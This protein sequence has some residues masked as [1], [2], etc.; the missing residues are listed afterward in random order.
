MTGR[1]YII[2]LFVI[3]ACWCFF[4]V[5]DLAMAQEA[6][7]VRVGFYD[8]PPKLFYDA[9][10]IPRGIFP[11]ILA[12]IAKEENW[13]IK[14]VPGTWL[15]GLANLE[16]GSIDIL[17]D[18]AYSLKKAGKYCF[19]EE[20]VFVNWGTLYARSGLLITKIPDLAGKRVAVM[21][22]SIHTDGEEGIRNLVRKF[23]I[24]C[25]FIEFDNY[26][27]VFQ[28]LQ[29]D[30]ADVGVVNRLFGTTSQQL[31]DV[32]PTPVV[33]NPRHLK[34]AFPKNGVATPY[35]KSTIDHHLQSAHLDRDSKITRIVNSYVTDISMRLQAEARQIYLTAEEKAWIKAH[36][37]IRVGID[38]EF[39]PFEYLDDNGNYSGFASDYINLL[40][41]RLGLNLEVVNGLS[42]QEVMHRARKRK[43]DML[44]AIGFS[45]QRSGFLSYSI[46]YS[47]FYRM[48]FCRSDAPFISGVSD[49]KRLKIAVQANTSHSAW[50][51]EHTS[52]VP[53]YYDTLQDTI[54]AVSRGR[55]DV[56]IG[57]LAVCTYWIRKLN[58]TN[59]RVAAPV[60]LERQLLYMGVRKD[61]PQLTGILNKGIRSIS[62]K[63]AEAIRN[64]WLAAGYSVG[65]SRKIIYQRL[66][67]ILF[68]SLFVLAFFWFWNKRLL[69]EIIRRKQAEQSLLAIQGKLVEKVVE[70]T[71]KLEENK[72]YLQSIFNAP[73]EAIF[74]HDAETGAILDVNKTTL[75]MFNVTYEEALQARP[76]DFSQGEY[77]YNAEE[78]LRKIR[79]TGKNG[80][81]T[82]EWLSRKKNGTLFWTEV[83]LTLTSI[84]DRTYIIAVVRNIDEKKK[85][86]QRLRAEQERLAVTLRSIGEG[87]IAVDTKGAVVL[88]NRVAEELTGWSFA[89]AKGVPY[90]KVFTVIDEKSGRQLENPI[91][92]AFQRGTIVG[93]R[94]GVALMAKDGSRKS[95]ADSCAPIRDREGRIIG[96]VLVFRDIT[97]ERKMEEELLK[98][99]K[100]EAVGILA[101]GI[102]HDFNNILTAVTGNIELSIKKAEKNTDVTPL[103]GDAL[104]A[105]ERAEK[106]T[107]QLLTFAKG[108]E[109]IKETASL[110][111]LIRDS[112]DFVLHGSGVSCTYA[113]AEDLWL[114]DVDKGQISQVVQNIIINARQAM[115]AGGT[116]TITCVN[117]AS[118]VDEPFPGLANKKYV[119]IIT[120]DTGTGIA[121][122]DI[123]KVFD[124]FFSSRETGSGLG[125]AICHSIVTKHHGRIF[126]DSTP[127]VGT[128]FT[129]YL[130][131]SDADGERVGDM[132][133]K[134]DGK[135]L[136]SARIMVMDDEELFKKVVK[137][138]LEY[139]G[140][141]VVFV[142][143]GREAVACYRDL[144]GTEEQIDCIIMDLTIPGGVGGKEAVREILAIDPDARV[145]V[146][147]GYFNDPV[148]ANYMEYGFKAAVA[149]PFKLDELQR[150]ISSVFA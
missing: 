125:L 51:R 127:G 30:L 2:L 120:C 19:S 75:T 89:E 97:N 58:I 132:D 95:I 84:S 62:A 65:I 37:L 13:R 23:N 42:W 18:V 148:M 135:N 11:E 32:L 110:A 10:G 146:A 100:L 138:Q 119:K 87:V 60:S 83:S 27:N 129:I 59:L 107:K 21:R 78:A 150:V 61:W 47:G 67:V 112:A 133:M 101:G 126:V 35:L 63:D 72:N 123:D 38:P 96:V 88:L 117:I 137:S 69:Q 102:A 7:V 81:Q 103:L 111:G 91:D 66:A 49:L 149:K 33:F 145:I 25:T 122:K 70:R 29:N 115:P 109:P 1:F 131:A 86:E 24:S 80:P 39:A 141:E 4:P 116:I 139:L 64:R 20:A 17:P 14:W 143:D 94:H 106:L 71:R 99:R 147:S 114:V 128:T 124:P 52:F 140:H 43:I 36:P 144:L 44:S 77:P 56:F 45:K 105:C 98:V 85:S 134:E 113:F 48:I 34:F 108:G 53:H 12:V 73:N 92:K 40:K 118:G 26:Q 41:Q 3:L 121:G 54:L 68:F 5:H 79:I 136:R 104:K 76:E 142:A 93:F 74:I 28:A 6:R 22:G 90:T 50:I 8:N 31:Y 46:P 9:Q 130:P 57:N 55:D 82:F 16:S 15:Q